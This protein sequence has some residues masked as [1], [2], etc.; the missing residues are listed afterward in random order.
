MRVTQSTIKTSADFTLF[1]WWFATLLGASCIFK[2]NYLKSVYDIRVILHYLFNPIGFLDHYLYFLSFFIND[3]FEVFLITSLIYIIGRKLLRLDLKVLIVITTPI[4]LFFAM[5]NLLSF[6]QLR[7]ALTFETLW[8]SISWILSDP[9][10]IESFIRADISSTLVS[11]RNL[12]PLV[13]IIAWCT[14]PYVFSKISMYH[15]R[16]DQEQLRIWLTLSF[17]MLTLAGAG[18]MS[19]VDRPLS[20]KWWGILVLFLMTTILASYQLRHMVSWLGIASRFQAYATIAFIPP[21]LFSG[22]FYLFGGLNSFERTPLL[23]EGHWSTIATSLFSNTPPNYEDMAVPPIDDLRQQYNALVYPQEGD[24]SVGSDL[25][26]LPADQIKPR[27][28]VMFSLETAFQRHY[29][30]FDDADLPSFHRVSRQAIVSEK[31][32]TVAPFTISAALSMLSGIYPRRNVSGNF[33]PDSLPHV[34]AKHGYVSTYID[35]FRTDWVLGEKKNHRLFEALGF[36][37]MLDMSTVP[38]LAEDKEFVNSY[39]RVLRQEEAAFERALATVQDAEIRDQPAFVFVQ[40]V[41]GH[42][43]WRAPPS[44]ENDQAEAKIRGL[45]NELDR[46]LGVFL[47]GLNKDGLTDDVIIVIAGDHG[48]RHVNEFESLGFKFAHSDLAFNVPLIIS[49]PGLLRKQVQIPYVTSH[50]DLAPTLLAMIGVPSDGLFFH[51]DN[52]LNQKVSQRVT[53]LLNTKLSPVDGFHWND[54]FITFDRTSGTAQLALEAT[55]SDARPLA[56]AIQKGASLPAS[57]ARPQ[58]MIESANEI[59]D[60]TIAHFIRHTPKDQ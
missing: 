27:H 10:A 54:N 25:L 28:I 31:H 52:F 8:I 4:L 57:F 44:H 43:P 7:T 13:A 32:Q 6:N 17:I 12:A 24:G 16:G 41:L 40:S 19:M 53:F 47:D 26:V 9:E 56:D 49:A 36:D 42:F 22:M 23:Q 51:G 30:L 45:A 5:A 11:S 39:Q 21:I 38:D 58:A 18:T 35:A 3:T 20:A 48:L 37:S 1:L 33:T 2:L 60:L 50:I 15:R 14:L 55:R 34:L 59:V 29:R 46:L